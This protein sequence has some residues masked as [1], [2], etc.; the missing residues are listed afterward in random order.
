M[1]M[2][3]QDIGPRTKVPKVN[4]Y[5]WVITGHP[6]QLKYLNKQ[7]LE[8]DHS[9]Q[10]I[11][12]NARVLKLARRW[13]WLACGVLIV[14]LREG[15]YFV[16]DGQHRLLA[17]M[18]RSDIDRLPCLVFPTREAVDEAIAFRDSNKERRPVSTF[19]QWN[20]NLVA[21]EPVTLFCSELITSIGRE[22]SGDARSNTVSCLNSLMSAASNNREELLRIFPLVTSVCEGHPFHERVFNAILYLECYI[23]NGETLTK[24]RWS[25]RIMRIGYQGVLDAANRAASFY[26]KGGPKVWAIGLMT[27][28]NKGNRINVLSIRTAK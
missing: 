2:A 4:Q 3:N 24:K 6:G 12:K 9:Y 1:E 25:D 23:E 11:A 13:N 18:K 17:A 28:L 19:E 26:S 14:G 5:Q 15:R 20:A 21:N 10:R 7:L 16:I 8:V 22:P 27:E